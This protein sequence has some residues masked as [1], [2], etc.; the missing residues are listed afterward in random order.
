ME[1]VFESKN[2]LR[3]TFVELQNV[4]DLIPIT[5]YSLAYLVPVSVRC[6]ARKREVQKTLTNNQPPF[7]FVKCLREWKSPPVALLLSKPFLVQRGAPR[8]PLA[9]VQL[10]QM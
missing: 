9:S 6:Y 10:D 4:P 3:Y 5:S 2:L 1:V 7:P 8:A